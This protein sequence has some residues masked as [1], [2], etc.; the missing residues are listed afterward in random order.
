MMTAK[1]ALSI[2]SIAS[3]AGLLAG[4]GISRAGLPVSQL[5]PAAQ[6]RADRSAATAA[7]AKAQALL[8]VTDLTTDHVNVYSYATGTLKA[9]MKGFQAVHYECVDAA[10]DVF[11]AD[12]GAEEL[13]EYAHGGTQPIKTYHEPGFVHGCAIDPITGDLAVL[14]DP[15]S[16]GPG[17]VS[18]YRHAKGTPKEYTT[19]NVYQVYFIG[20]GGHGGLYVDGTDMHVAFEMAKLPA[21]GSAFKA[22]TLDQ[23]IILP[24]AIQWDGKDLAVGD[25]V[26]INGPSKIYEF[27]MKG[28]TGTLVHTTPLTDSC[29]VLQ[30]WIQGSRVITSNDCAPHVLYFDYPKG[31]LSIKTVGDSLNQPVGVAVSL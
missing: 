13:L 6:A 15:Q 19:P 1:S 18:I 30:F 3:T 10:R 20:Y 8:Y 22:V 4:C 23:S 12:S 25:Q 2:L 26:S 17:G 27:S 16:Q 11:I 5:Q 28:A 31:G 21:G 7:G 24:G 29:D 9:V 14:H